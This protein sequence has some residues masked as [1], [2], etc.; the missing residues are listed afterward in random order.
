MTN[1]VLGAAEAMEWGIVN[2]VV[3]AA[4]L[5]KRADALAADIAAGP[6]RS[7]AGIKKLLHTGWTES[8]ESQMA[9][10][11]RVIAGVAGTADTRE[12]IAAFL[13]KREPR[14]SVKGLV[15]TEPIRFG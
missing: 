7:Y 1:R 4:E 5:V 10:E 14:F 11:V 2:E 9:R 13:D 3:P 8:L 12:G 15:A 6:A